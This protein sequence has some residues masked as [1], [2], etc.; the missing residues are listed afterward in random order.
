MR[1]RLRD[2]ADCIIDFVSPSFLF[3]SPI[4]KEGKRLTGTSQR[5]LGVDLAKLG[6]DL[7]AQLMGGSRTIA[8]LSGA[9]ST[10]DSC[11]RAKPVAS[12]CA[13][14]LAEEGCGPAVIGIWCAPPP[15]SCGQIGSPGGGAWLAC[16]EQTTGEG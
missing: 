3:W 15:I 6:S 7:A 10:T 13:E 16:A 5:F 12:F 8:A 4:R 9:T 2:R 11:C 1:C 14:F